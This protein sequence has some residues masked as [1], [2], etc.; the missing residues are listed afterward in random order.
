[1]PRFLPAGA[2]PDTAQVLKLA[3]GLRP[4]RGP[5]T[6]SPR[7]PCTTGRRTRLVVVVDQFEEVFTY[8]PRDEQGGRVRA[9]PGRVLRQ[10]P[11]CRGHAGGRVAVVLT[12][13]SDFLA[14]APVPAARRGVQRPPGAGRAD[15][16]GE[17]REA[18]EQPA[19]LV[20]CEVQPGLTERLLADVEGQPG[21]LPL[22]QFALT[23]VWKQRDVRRLTLRAYDEL[24]GIEGP[25]S[26]G[27]TRSTAT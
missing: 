12:M 19:V 9:G 4:T 16:A 10:P 11:A 7:W 1:M 14:P 27:R 18:I 8:R 15:G 17:L 13:R 25:W 3:D 20:S 23:E 6:S 26:T 22:M 5:S 24:G 21:A 2:L